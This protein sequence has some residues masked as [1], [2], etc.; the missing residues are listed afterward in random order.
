MTT[1]PEILD[2]T[3]QLIQNGWCQRTSARNNRDIPV[4]HDDPTAT[5]WCVLGALEKTLTEAQSESPAARY[6]LRK[7]VFRAIK[8]AA[9]E[10]NDLAGW[11]DATGRTL[12]GIVNLLEESVKKCTT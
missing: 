4:R 3:K 10:I 8:K 12:S 5:Q 9:P 7:D 11:N 1:A 2:K 6:Y